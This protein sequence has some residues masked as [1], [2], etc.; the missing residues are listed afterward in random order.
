MRIKA[1]KLEGFE[2]SKGLLGTKKP[3]AVCFRT[4]WGIHTFFM[5]FNIDVLIINN[6]GRVASFKENLKPW[7]IYFWNPIHENVV[8]LPKGT[9]N[10]LSIEINSIITVEKI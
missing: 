4:R 3:E 8:E 7:R 2:K 10:S 6:E 9:I 1:K 5:K